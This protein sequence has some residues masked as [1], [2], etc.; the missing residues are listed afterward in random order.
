[1]IGVYFTSPAI[2]VELHNLGSDVTLYDQGDTRTSVGNR[3]NYV[4]DSYLLIKKHPI[5]GY[6][7]G[8]YKYEYAKLD[9]A[10]SKYAP[11][12]P[13]NDFYLFWVE[14]GVIGLLVFVIM[15]LSIIHYSYK[16]KTPESIVALAIIV[17]YSIGAFQGGFFQDNITKK[18]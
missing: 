1:M 15:I 7:T 6:G 8:S 18:S 14:N 17:S 4:K 10:N 16:H 11:V 3:I 13:H 5:I 9:L 2:K 12:H